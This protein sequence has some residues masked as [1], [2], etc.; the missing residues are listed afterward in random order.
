[1]ATFATQCCDNFT[2]SFQSCDTILSTR[3]RRYLLFAKS[4]AYHTELRTYISVPKNTAGSSHCKLAISITSFGSTSTFTC[5][6][7]CR[8]SFTLFS[9]THSHQSLPGTIELIGCSRHLQLVPRTPPGSV[10]TNATSSEITSFPLHERPQLH[11]AFGNSYISTIYT[12]CGRPTPL[13]SFT[14]CY[15]STEHR[16]FFFSSAYIS[17][18]PPAELPVRTEQPRLF[19][20]QGIIAPRKNCTEIC[21]RLT[22][23]FCQFSPPSRSVMTQSKVVRLLKALFSSEVENMSYFHSHCSLV[24]I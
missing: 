6:L 2:I 4:T 23:S 14:N 18:L 10:T 15:H 9:T 1:M 16:A 7:S 13:P 24:K 20:F 3:H 17:A 12:D 5:A 8:Y 22:K 21:C 11:L 19:F